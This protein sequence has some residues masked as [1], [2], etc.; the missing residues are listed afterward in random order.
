[1]PDRL[2]IDYDVL[3]D[4]KRDMERLAGDI[5]P[6]LDSS[7]FTELA[8]GG[9]AAAVLGSV[10]VADAVSGLRAEA[11]NTLSRAYDG[12]KELAGAFGSVGEAFL[13]FD[14]ELAQ[15]MGIT[16]SNLGLGNYLRQKEQWDYRQAHLDQCVPGPDGSMPDFCSATDPGPNPPVDQTITTERGSVQT[17]LTL[18]GENHVI[19]EESTVTYDGKT[20]TST[21]TY[22]DNGNTY[23]TDTAY[24]DGSTVRSETHL[25]TDGSGTMTVTNSDGE[26]TDY[27]RGPRPAEG[28]N[29][30]DWD[31]VGGDNS[32]SA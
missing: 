22:S 10:D 27:T 18:D 31:Q 16:G 8:T 6:I 23:V 20:Y 25:N 2:R 14:S 11:K 3:N 1:M 12:L 13:S 21:T 7:L 9:D 4:A 19:K 15:G 30:P 26:R 29:P 28:Q 17:H 5:G 32:D 24:P